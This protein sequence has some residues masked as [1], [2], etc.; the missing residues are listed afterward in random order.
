MSDLD[1]AT[2]DSETVDSETVDSETVDTPGDKTVSSEATYDIFN[3]HPDDRAMFNEFFETIN[4]EQMITQFPMELGTEVLKLTV[5]TP[6]IEIVVVCREGIITIINWTTFTQMLDADDEEAFS[7]E[8][9][10][11]FN[12]ADNA[13]RTMT[14]LVRIILQQIMIGERL[15]DD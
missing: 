7:D 12:T 10:L 8:V 2:V 1:V 13:A 14:S 4:S 5:T 15:M 6:T 9:F 3:P 11:K